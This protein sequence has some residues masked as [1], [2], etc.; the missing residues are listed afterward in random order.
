MMKPIIIRY[1]LYSGAVAAAL[2]SLTTLYFHRTQDFSNGQWF[3][4]AG[5][6]LSMIWVFLGVKTYREQV[7]EGYLSLGKGFQVGIAIAVISCVCYVLAWMLVSSV[8]MPDFMDVYVEQAITQLRA[9]GASETEIT[10]QMKE[11]SAFQEMYKNPLI[12]F[13]LTFLEPFPAGFL[14]ALVSALIL[15]KNPPSESV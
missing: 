4:Y 1:G 12:K 10:R 5:I 13:G 6:L 7:G 14:V 9:S 3:G 15:R 11:M 2:M 8:F